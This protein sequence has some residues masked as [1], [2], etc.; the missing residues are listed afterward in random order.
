[1]KIIAKFIGEDSLGYEHGKS[2]VLYIHNNYIKRE[3]G[4]GV[5]P[6]NSLEL[7]FKN[8]TIL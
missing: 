8:W 7:F 6:Y 3:D 1:M 2:Y 5:C 4:S